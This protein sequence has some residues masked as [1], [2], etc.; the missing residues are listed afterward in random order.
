M[1]C[2]IVYSNLQDPNSKISHFNFAFYLVAE[3][4]NIDRYRNL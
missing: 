2:Q 1:L 3:Q 4:S